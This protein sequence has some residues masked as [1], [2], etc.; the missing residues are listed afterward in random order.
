RRGAGRRHRRAPGLAAR[1]GP[2]A[3]VILLGA[4]ADDVTGASDLCSTLA[5]EGMRTV[6]VLGDARDL[7]LP[8]V[9]AIVVA[10]KSRTAPVEQAVP[11]STEALAWLTGLGARRPSSSTARRST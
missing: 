10:L 3:R 7:E 11:E 2:G 8:D 9:D 1:T 5:R 6:Q 4:I